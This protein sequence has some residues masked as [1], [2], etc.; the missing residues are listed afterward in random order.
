MRKQKIYPNTSKDSCRGLLDKMFAEL[1]DHG[2]ELPRV[3]IAGE[4]PP[5]IATPLA[6]LVQKWN[7]ED[8]VQKQQEGTQLMILWSTYIQLHVC[9]Q[10]TEYTI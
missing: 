10:S 7:A 5:K 9:M 2:F 8:A 4:R 1:F 6:S 3:A